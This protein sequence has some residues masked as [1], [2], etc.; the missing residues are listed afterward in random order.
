MKVFAVIVALS[1]V[2]VLAYAAATAPDKVT[3]AAKNGAVTL[4][5]KKHSTMTGVTCKTCHHTM[6]G[7]T[8]DK[9]CSEC[10]TAQAD[11]KKLALKDAMHKT[12]KECHVKLK[13]G[14]STK[15]AECHKK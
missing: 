15:C 11:G 13:K 1:M 8:P 12:C 10:H 2:S 9:K 4:D 7:A 5:H 14:P 3:L 6:T